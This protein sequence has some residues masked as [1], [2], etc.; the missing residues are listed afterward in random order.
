VILLSLLVV[1]IGELRYKGDRMATSA[2][3]SRGLITVGMVVGLVVGL[4]VWCVAANY[5]AHVSAGTQLN[6]QLNNQWAMFNLGLTLWEFG[7]LLLFL[8]IGGG[9]SML[10]ESGTRRGRRARLIS[11]AV[12]VLLVVLSTWGYVVATHAVM[13]SAVAHGSQSSAPGVPQHPCAG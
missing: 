13:R 11:T 1:V 6:C 3:L 4:V 2:R 5:I 12:C 8:L 7:S 9:L 10:L